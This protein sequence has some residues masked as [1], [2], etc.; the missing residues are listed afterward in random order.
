MAEIFDTGR[1]Y[2]S[3]SCIP[4]VLDKIYF[5]A[6]ILKKL[7]FNLDKSPKNARTLPAVLLLPIPT[8]D[9]N[10]LKGQV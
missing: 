5:N 10:N 4:T 7:A 3:V 1:N 9:S 2:T 6:Q 8:S